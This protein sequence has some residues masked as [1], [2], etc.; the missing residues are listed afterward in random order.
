MVSGVEYESSLIV[1]SNIALMWK[2]REISDVSSESLSALHLVRPKPEL[3]LLGTGAANMTP[4][5]GL[6]EHL[7]ELGC[8]LD[9]SDS[10]SAASTF[11]LL[12]E[13]GRRVAAA[14]LP[15]Q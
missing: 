5:N 10:F 11:N 8:T 12:Q 14:L 15:L 9:V 13:E 4:P 3:V 2:A 1:Y 7:R 6:R